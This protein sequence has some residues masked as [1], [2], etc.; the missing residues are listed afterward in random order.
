M[1]WQLKP[2]RWLKVHGE[3]LMITAATKQMLEAHCCCPLRHRG[4]LIPS[5]ICWPSFCRLSFGSHGNLHLSWQRS[6]HLV[7]KH[8]S[9]KHGSPPQLL[10]WLLSRENSS[11]QNIN[12][13]VHSA[14]WY[15]CGQKV[16]LFI[17]TVNFGD[18]LPAPQRWGGVL[19]IVC[20]SFSLEIAVH[21]ASETIVQRSIELQRFTAGLV[22]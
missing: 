2:F 17:R 19:L 12:H 15:V 5:W 16:I 13:T 4:L 11:D 1:F 22:T 21:S 10:L 14:K 3:H 20:Y 18:W 6:K 7:T 9:R 8:G